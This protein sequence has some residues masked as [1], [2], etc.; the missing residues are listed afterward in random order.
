M[1]DPGRS[2]ILT[3]HLKEIQTAR[4]YMREKVSK[5]RAELKWKRSL[6]N[7]KNIPM[8]LRQEKIKAYEDLIYAQIAKIEKDFEKLQ[9]DKEKKLKQILER[10]K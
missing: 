9:A 3:S 6:Y 2:S 7:D 10:I 1:A 5:L 8:P 4:N